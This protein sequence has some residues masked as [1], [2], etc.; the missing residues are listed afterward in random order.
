MP[1]H[2]GIG[3]AIPIRE[4][5]NKSRKKVLNLPGMKAVVFVP[6]FLFVTI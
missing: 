1:G 2:S 3:E 5:L 6:G 4:D